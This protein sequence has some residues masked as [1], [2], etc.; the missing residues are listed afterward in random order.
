MAIADQIAAAAQAQGV[1]PALAIEIANVE[2]GLNPN[3]PNGAAGEV[4]MFQ[5]MPATAA[6]LGVNP[7]DPTQNIQGGISYLSQLLAEFGD[8]A[9]A[10]AAYN[11]GPG[12]VS[13]AVANYGTN[14]M[15]GIP[16]STQ[17]YVSKIMG[18]LQTAYTPS[19][20]PAGPSATGSVLNVS[21][22]APA[23]SSSIWTS[24]ALA[25]AVILGLG[26]ILS[27]S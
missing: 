7:Y 23:P 9:K 20:N 5:L 11:C 3:V 17:S 10:V 12:C 4:G 26:F 1:D 25:A 18:A 22:A 13:A 27:E 2:S 15:A 16:S 24:M 6:Q 19:F 14:W 8:P 21:P